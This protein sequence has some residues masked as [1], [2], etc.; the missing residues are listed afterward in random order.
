MEYTDYL[1]LE[2]I[3]LGVLKSAFLTPDREHPLYID[4]L[5]DEEKIKYL[6]ELQ[7]LTIEEKRAEIIKKFNK[8]QN[9]QI[10]A[11]NKKDEEIDKETTYLILLLKSI[12]FT[13][14]KDADYYWNNRY[15]YSNKE[16]S[17]KVLIEVAAAHPLIKGKPKP[18]FKERLLQAIELYNYEKAKGNS[19]IIYIPGSL[20][21]IEDKETGEKLVDAK[22]LSEAGKEFLIENGIPEESICANMRNID[23]KGEDGVY[24]SADECY[25]ATQIAKEQ[26]CQ[27]IISITSPVTIYRKALIYNELGYNPEIYSVGTEELNHNYI[28]ELFWSLYITYMND[29][30]WQSGF[31][32]FLTRLERDIDYPHTLGENLYRIQNIINNGKENS[33][34]QNV[35]AQ[36]EKWMNY[37]KTAQKN[38]KNANTTNANVLID[39]I[40]VNGKS[41]FEIERIK[42]ILNSN[43]EENPDTKVVIL[44]N[45]SGNIEDL[46]KLSNQYPSIILEP[47]G[48]KSNVVSTYK[49]RDFRKFYEMYPSSIA[50]KRAVE[51][52]K[53]GVIPIVSSVP[54]ENANYI[55]Q[56]SDL[57]DEVLEQTM[58]QHTNSYGHR[59]L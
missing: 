34:P 29:Q 9:C 36:R 39:L 41:E 57:L 7:L 55:E 10:K 37:Y 46:I 56:I 16:K 4:A 32:A 23:Y 21:Y 28:G 1:D 49:N 6:E 12:P 14:K 47:K 58:S 18:E 43:L 15:D 20:H 31:L 51:Y 13:E 48:E 30:D 25:V 17:G 33:I 52:I 2:H 50:M 44:F 5:S 8:I 38:M 40:R 11:K 3:D 59:E 35:R 45:P 19:P 53:E 22:P 27:R 54:D 26:G 24:N 42:S